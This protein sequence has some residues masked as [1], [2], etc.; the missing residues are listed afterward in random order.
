MT[1]PDPKY[2]KATTLRDMARALT[3]EPLDAQDPRHVDLSPARSDEDLLLLQQTLADGI[4][5]HRKGTASPVKMI[6][7]GPRGTGKTT[8]LERLRVIEDAVCLRF[9]LDESLYQDLDYSL[10]M[11]W[12]VEQLAQH[13]TD[14]GVPLDKDLL[15]DVADWFAEV[16]ETKED[17]DKIKASATFGTK[18][19]AGASFFGSE[20]SAFFGLRSL[21]EGSQDHRTQV[22]RG[23][24]RNAV[25]LVNRVNQVF[26]TAR[27]R[28]QAAGQP[29][30][31]LILQ[32]EVDRANDRAVRTMIRDDADTLKGLD[33][34]LV[35]TIPTGVPLPRVTF[36]ESFVLTTP[37]VRDR[38][39][40][41]FNSGLDALATVLAE[42]IEVAQTFETPDLLRDLAR[43][44]GGSLRDL[45][46]LTTDAA[47]FAR[48][49][50]AP[51]ISSAHVE[52]AVTRMRTDQDRFL[53]ED[54]RRYRTLARVHQTKYR[55]EA[56][57]DDLNR[58]ADLLDMGLMFPYNGM[59][60]WYDV[61]PVIE[62]SRAFQ[63][64]LREHSA[65]PTG[66]DD[67]D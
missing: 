27:E 34:H 48:L 54:A 66:G 43:W 46:R 38:T 49:V 8:E 50:N 10:L 23:L 53:Q 41:D 36:P 65:S 7:Q 39:G 20:V 9:D 56:D 26:A 24:R 14:R 60:N 11:L 44:C 22:R 31:L 30:S 3:T 47:R 62:G 28:L 51:K 58:T 19:K 15:E 63:D 45:M 67:G 35:L 16:T 4:A 64:A 25:T 59:D 55:T 29:S 18:A 5:D 37:K 12:L 61:H 1:E 40:A 2:A 17:V 21:I 33:V 42:R 32:D 6:L 13:M 52:R 57:S